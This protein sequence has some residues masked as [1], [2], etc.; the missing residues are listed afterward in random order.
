MQQ[1]VLDTSSFRPGRVLAEAVRVWDFSVPDADR[2]SET[3][4]RLW[5]RGW[6]ATAVP[7]GSISW[8]IPPGRCLAIAAAAC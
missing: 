6:R 3:D 2:W 1:R 5:G 8:A 7:T 4:Q